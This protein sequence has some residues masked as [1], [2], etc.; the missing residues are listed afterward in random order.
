M[1]RG[2]Q[3]LML[4]PSIKVDGKV[5]KVKK[6]N[7]KAW[8]KIIKLQTNESGFNSEEGLDAMLDFI[9]GVFKDPN[10]TPESI[11]D[12]LDLDEFMPLFKSIGDYIGY[13]IEQKIP[14]LGE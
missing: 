5:Y 9:A 10:V 1:Y 3:K 6:P 7:M 4:A 12:N 2:G 8:R 14:K 13:I 11:E